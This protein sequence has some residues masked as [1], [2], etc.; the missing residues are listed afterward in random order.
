MRAD[1]RRDSW[2]LSYAV[3]GHT[4]PALNG[5]TVNDRAVWSP[6]TTVQVDDDEYGIYGTFYISDVQYQRDGSGTRTM[7]TLID[8]A[9]WVP[10]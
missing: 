9:D 8:P 5:R 1:D 2:N 6:D 10:P 4:V 3:S 7:L